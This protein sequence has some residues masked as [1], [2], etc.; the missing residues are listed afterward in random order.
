MISKKVSVFERPFAARRREKS[1]LPAGNYVSLE[2]TLTFLLN[3]SPPLD[4]ELN[5]P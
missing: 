1:E 4:Y 3:T 5:T 2:N